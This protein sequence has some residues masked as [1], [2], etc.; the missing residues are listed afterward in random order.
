MGG[1]NMYIIRDI[2]HTGNSG[3]RGDPKDGYKYNCRRWSRVTLGE[4]IPG[5]ST[6]IFFDEPDGY[7]GRYIMTT[8]VIG[9]KENDEGII[10]ETI[11]SIYVLERI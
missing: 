10:M 5:H 8:P 9:Y 11:N 3:R 1:D 2:L 7:D 6:L 4:M